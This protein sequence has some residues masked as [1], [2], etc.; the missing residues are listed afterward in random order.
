VAFLHLRVCEIPVRIR[1]NQAVAGRMLHVWWGRN[2]CDHPLDGLCA[3]CGPVFVD[4]R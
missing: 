1:E 4:R 3:N 2:G